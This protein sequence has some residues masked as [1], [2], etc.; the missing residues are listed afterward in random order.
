MQFNADLLSLRRVEPALALVAEGRNFCASQ[1]QAAGVRESVER[2]T[3]FLGARARAG[4]I[5]CD[6]PLRAYLI[7][8]PSQRTEEPSPQPRQTR[9]R[10]GGL[11]G[12][13]VRPLS[14][15]SP[16]FYQNDSLYFYFLFISPQ[17]YRYS[18]LKAYK[19]KT[20]ALFLAGAPLA[21]HAQQ[22]AARAFVL[23]PPTHHVL[24]RA[25]TLP[26]CMRSDR[27]EFG[28]GTAAQFRMICC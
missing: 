22:P 1:G 20:S 5:F 10:R 6:H 4:V 12:G 7:L 25:H 8:A 11:R 24:P 26:R 17:G 27:Q 28:V 21:A 14:D 13:G 19:K 9:P 15:P 18:A 16:E 2:E 3:P 23:R